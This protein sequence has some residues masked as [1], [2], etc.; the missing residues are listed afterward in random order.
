MGE[1]IKQLILDGLFC[2][3]GHHK[4]WYLELLYKEIEGEEAP[5]V[6]P[7]ETDPDDYY[8]REVGIAP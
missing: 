3:G 8:S 6:L 2:D 7:H 1:S 5:L 4:L